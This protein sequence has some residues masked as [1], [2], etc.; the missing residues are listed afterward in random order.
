MISNLSENDRVPIPAMLFKSVLAETGSKKN[1]S[2]GAPML[3]I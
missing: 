3:Q 2:A 1:Q